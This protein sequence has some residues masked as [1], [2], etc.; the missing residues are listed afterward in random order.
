MCHTPSSARHNAYSRPCFGPIAHFCEAPVI[1]DVLGGYVVRV[2]P[3]RLVDL[4][5]RRRE[6][7]VRP[8]RPAALQGVRHRL[9][10]RRPEEAGEA[11]AQMQGGERALTVLRDGGAWLACVVEEAERARGR[12]E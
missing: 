10:E 12:E 9:A 7:V 6:L 11:L 8:R 5:G 3:D 4:P 2:P 1:V